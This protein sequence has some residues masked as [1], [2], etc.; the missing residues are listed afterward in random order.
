[1]LLLLEDDDDTGAGGTNRLFFGKFGEG[2]V[3]LGVLKFSA[4][5]VGVPIFLRT[6]LNW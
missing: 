3:A 4:R 5:E 2:I 1:M 6:N